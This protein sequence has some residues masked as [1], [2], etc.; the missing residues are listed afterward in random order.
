MIAPSS[1]GHAPSPTYGGGWSRRRVRLTGIPGVVL[2]ELEDHA[3]AMRC[4]LHHADGRITAIEPDFHRVPLNTC[5]GAAIPLRELIGEPVGLPARAFFVGGRARRNCTHMFDLAW[6]A[7]RQAARGEGSRTY[8][9]DMRDSADETAE[10]EAR[11]DGRLLFRWRLEGD[12]IAEPAP[13][14][15]LNL[16]KGFATWLGDAPDLADEVIEAAMM[17]Q[18]LRMI[19]AARQ[20]ILPPGLLGPRERQAVAGA[21]HGYAAAT[22]EEAFRP[23]DNHRDFS[24]QPERLLRFF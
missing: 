20:Y 4:R 9:F 12:V 13:F 1:L 16:F 10:L 3:H 6:L 19:E 8:A 18:K 11:L 5:P 15:G 17:A 24:D 7:S 21:C 23:G 2:A 14:A 22:I